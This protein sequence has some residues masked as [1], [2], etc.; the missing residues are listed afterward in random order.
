MDPIAHEGAGLWNKF[1]SMGD[2]WA[3]ANQGLKPFAILMS[4]DGHASCTTEI[5]ALRFLACWSGG[6]RE[7]YQTVY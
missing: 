7:R 5:L 3:S 2:A 6:V 1:S 4:G